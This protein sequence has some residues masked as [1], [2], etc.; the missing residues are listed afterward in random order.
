MQFESSGFLRRMRVS[1]TG[2]NYK[3]QTDR[4]WQFSSSHEWHTTGLTQLTHSI[5]SNFEDPS[6]LF[7]KNPTKTWWGKRKRK[8]Q[9]RCDDDDFCWPFSQ[10]IGII[11]RP[12]RN[13]RRNIG[14]STRNAARSDLHRFCSVVVVVVLVWNEDRWRCKKSKSL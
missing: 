12:E 2:Q 7:T 13:R 8:N 9:R 10:Q 11:F 1:V 14:L 3:E 4:M 5:I 6:I